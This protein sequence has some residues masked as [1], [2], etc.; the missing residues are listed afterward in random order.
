VGKHRVCIMLII[1]NTQ[2]K[3]YKDID[4]WEQNNNVNPNFV[5]PTSD[6]K[7]V[8]EAWRQFLQSN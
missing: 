3:I 5:L 4:A 8:V 7:I 1:T 6:F 2:T